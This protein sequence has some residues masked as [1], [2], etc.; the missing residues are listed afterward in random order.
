MDTRQFDDLAKA[1]R[2]GANR[3]RVLGLLTGGLAA[4]GVRR[5]AVGEHKDDHCAKA[6]QKAQPKKPCCVGVAADDG[7][8]PA[9]CVNPGGFGNGIACEANHECCS[10]CCVH[11][12]GSHTTGG[13]CGLPD[14]ANVLEEC[15][16][17]P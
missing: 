10:G 6:G 16:K 9:E 12:A 7:R 4:L 11:T 17:V 15:S 2:W 5:A 8:C 13:L 1:L 3:R 14:P